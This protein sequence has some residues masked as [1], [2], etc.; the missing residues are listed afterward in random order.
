MSRSDERGKRCR[1]ACPTEPPSARVVLLALRRR[2]IYGYARRCRSTV[3]P[4]SRSPP[5]TTLPDKSAS[6]ALSRW[7]ATSASWG[8]RPAICASG[9]FLPAG[10]SPEPKPQCQDPRRP[11][12]VDLRRPGPTG[13][14]PARPERPGEHPHRQ[15][16]REMDGPVLVLRSEAVRGAH[17]LAVKPPL[18][19]PGLD[20]VAGR[21]RSGHVVE[22]SLGPILVGQERRVRQE[23]LGR[24]APRGEDLAGLGA[25]RVG[26]RSRR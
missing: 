12:D 5:S 22:P 17:V 8:A 6:S 14:C 16:D 4:S 2:Q 23:R 20:Q 21:D 13:R 18:D 9:F 15:I 3:S 24:L 10:T 11:L 19:H 1:G 7:P 26:S 25:R